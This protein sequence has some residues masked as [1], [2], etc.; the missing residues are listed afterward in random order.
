MS[1]INAIGIW[2]SGRPALHRGSDASSQSRRSFL[3]Y[4]YATFNHSSSMGSPQEI[5]E[6]HTRA[7]PAN[8]APRHSLEIAGAQAFARARTGNG[9]VQRA[10][11]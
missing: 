9:A 8:R 2:S 1:L 7:S 11:G 3:Q 10:T 4:E 5:N 6:P